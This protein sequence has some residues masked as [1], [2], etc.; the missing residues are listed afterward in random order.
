VFFVVIVKDAD[1]YRIDDRESASWAKSN[2][3]TLRI[4]KNEN[5]NETATPHPLSTGPILTGDFKSA[6]SFEV[7][8]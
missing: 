4:E 5:R 2:D 8:R 7:W 6:L 1:R 3:L